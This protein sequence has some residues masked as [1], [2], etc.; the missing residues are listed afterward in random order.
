MVNA[1]ARLQGGAQRGEVLAGQTTV[2]LTANAVSYGPERT[3]AAKGFEGEGVGELAGFPVEGLTTR[4]SRRTIPFVGRGSELSI[5]RESLARTTASGRPVLVTVVGEPGIG[6]TRLADELVAG[7]GDEV[8]VLLGRARPFTDTETFAPA[9]AIVGELAE[10]DEADPPDKA[11][12]RLRELVERVSPPGATD[13]DVEQLALLFG[14]A[15]RRDE[16]SFVQDVQHGFVALMTACSDEQPVLLV[17]ED[18][19]TLRPP[20]LELIERVAA[21]SQG[22]RRAMLL[23]LARPQLL[24]E[25]PAWGRSADNAVQLRLDPLSEE[26]SIELVRQASGGSIDEGEATE[27]GRRAGGNPFFIVESTGMLLPDSSASRTA[28]PPTVQ[29]VVSARLDALPT[30][31]RELARRASTFFVSFD[32]DELHTIDPETTSDEL[33]ELEEA[34]I[35][36]REERTDVV[37][38]RVRHAT[39]KEVAYASLPKRERVR[40][41]QL[42]ADRL[43]ASGHPTWA[44]DHLELAALASLD[45]DP[46][47]RGCPNAPPTRSSRRATGRGAGSRAA[48]RSIG[49]SGRWRSRVRSIDGRVREARAL[50]GIGEGHYWLGE[51]PAATDALERAVQLGTKTGD[52]FALSLA[53]RFLGDIAINVEADLDKADRL[54]GRSLAAAEELGDPWAI[55][56]TLLFAGWVPWTRN[57]IQ[58]SERIWR[59]ALEVADP[60]DGW[61]RVRA[62]NSLSINRTGGPGTDPPAGGR[63][64]RAGPERQALELAEETG[65]RFSVAMASVQRARALDDLDRREEAL[66]VGTARSR[67]SRSS[68]RG[69]SSRTRWPGAGSSCA[70]SAA[71]TRPRRTCTPRSASP[72]TSASARWA[73]GP[74]A[75][76]PLFPSSAATRPRPRSGGAGHGRRRRRARARSASGA[77]AQNFHH[78]R[79]FGV[80]P[81][82]A[83]SSAWMRSASC[84]RCSCAT[85]LSTLSFS[86][87]QAI[88]PRSRPPSPPGPCIDMVDSFRS[89]AAESCAKLTQLD[90]VLGA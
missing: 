23:A 46:D 37:R 84:A 54:L 43:V 28:L 42:I 66:P 18:A 50:A 41:H 40:L 80:S 64:G 67:S 75:P 83:A 79:F 39:V 7:L 62:L 56:R 20:M 86:E 1:A 51:Y 9:A 34:E 60:E 68:G 87:P 78:G 27:I 49:T 36:V 90:T 3:I 22:R 59:R 82:S 15:D 31:L 53:L 26:E 85:A 61:A 47:D 4:S 58:E 71:S 32:V 16:S 8:H 89:S 74:G 63:R 88:P 65:D 30:R 5:L 13:R 55:T 2:A 21:R 29:A 69:G 24:D 38:W 12:Q 35:I 33:R 45:L 70:S 10:L 14:L 81:R 19:H 57:R 72:R 25:R 48:R 44:A 52:A 11:R 77:Q 73:A 76:S 17:F 6:K